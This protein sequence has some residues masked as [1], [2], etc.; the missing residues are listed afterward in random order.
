MCI[1]DRPAPEVEGIGGDT[2]ANQPDKP[3]P[4]ME[5]IV[6]DNPEKQPDRPTQTG[7]VNFQDMMMGMLEKLNNNMESMKDENIIYW[8]GRNTNIVDKVMKSV[9]IQKAKIE[10]EQKNYA[11]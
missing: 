11:G 3:A 5:V 6:G 8:I 4:E 1:R 2:L 10:P 7:E 9:N